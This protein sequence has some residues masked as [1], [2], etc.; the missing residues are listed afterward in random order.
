[1]ERSIN[2]PLRAGLAL[3][4]RRRGRREHQ[5]RSSRAPAP[6]S[7]TQEHPEGWIRSQTERIFWVGM[8]RVSSFL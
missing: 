8:T 3:P 4:E 7:A 2:V 1:M 5:G 6:W